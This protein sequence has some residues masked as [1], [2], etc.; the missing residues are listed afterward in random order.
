LV[1]DVFLRAMK[2]LTDIELKK[3]SIFDL[4]DDL[5]LIRKIMDM[6]EINPDFPLNS[7]AKVESLLLYAEYFN[8]VEFEKRIKKVFKD[9]WEECI[10]YD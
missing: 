3:A 1:C 4:T 5:K 7:N 9:E 2:Q 10:I 6:G 8:D